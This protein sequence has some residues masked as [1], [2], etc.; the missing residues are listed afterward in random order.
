MTTTTS[1]PWMHRLGIITEYIN[2]HIQKSEQECSARDDAKLF[3]MLKLL[4]QQLWQSFLILPPG[5]WI[6]LY[7]W[8]AHRQILSSIRWTA[9][10]TT[11][12]RIWQP[13]TAMHGIYKRIKQLMAPLL[14]KVECSEGQLIM[15]KD[16]DVKL[17][18]MLLMLAQQIWQCFLILPPGL[19]IEFSTHNVHI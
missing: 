15:F 18:W 7:S 6:S 5:L 12:G 19:W 10:L 2:W 1:H 3:W 4:S 13:P 9:R 14:S 11:L 16:D 8:C 17:P